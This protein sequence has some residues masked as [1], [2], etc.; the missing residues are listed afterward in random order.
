MTRKGLDELAKEMPEMKSVEQSE[1]VGA[2]RF[3]LNTGGFTKEES[4]KIGE[5]E[6]IRILTSQGLTEVMGNVN[7]EADF[8]S[9]PDYC[10]PLF[11]S[12]SGIENCSQYNFLIIN[13]QI[14]NK[15]QSHGINSGYDLTQ[16]S[17]SLS[18]PL[19][20]SFNDPILH[21]ALPSDGHLFQTDIDNYYEYIQD[22]YDSGL[23]L[24]QQGLI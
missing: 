6:E 18:I 13:T 2:Y 21:I 4:F 19:D 16:V 9:N 17:E 20:T 10:K 24:R 5:S 22:Y 1:C 15:I 11:I 8:F 3:Y 7:L 23:I 12:N 14:L